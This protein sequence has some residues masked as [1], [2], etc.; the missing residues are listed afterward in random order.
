[1]TKLKAGI[2][3]TITG[4]L[5][6]CV[7]YLSASYDYRWYKVLMTVFAY[8]GCVQALVIF[9]KFLREPSADPRHAEVVVA[10]GKTIPTSW[11][12]PFKIV[13]AKEEKDGDPKHTG[14]EKNGLSNAGNN[15]TEAKPVSSRPVESVRPGNGNRTP[16]HLFEDCLAAREPESAALG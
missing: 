5:L 10:S 9:Y 13:N 7:I 6:F 11:L 3:T 12:D 4:V 2:I 1:M 15:A 16:E 14:T 8:Y